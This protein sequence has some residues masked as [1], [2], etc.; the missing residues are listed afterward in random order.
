MKGLR[1][2]N[3]NINTKICLLLEIK[4]NF[5]ITNAEKSIRVGLQGVCLR[6]R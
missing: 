3:F 2:I 4:R 6:L 1:F 5:D